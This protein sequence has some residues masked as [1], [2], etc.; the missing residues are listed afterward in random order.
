M[1]E[2][3]AKRFNLSLLISATVAVVVIL[4]PLSTLAAPPSKEGNPG[5]PGLLYELQ[6]QIQDQT[7]TIEELQATIDAL[8]GAIE[9]MVPAPVPKTGQIECRD[10]GY[11][12][13]DCSGTG[14]DGDNQAGAEWPDPRFTDNGDGT[15]TDKL[16]GLIW[17][18]NYY[19]AEGNNAISGTWEYAL[20]WVNQLGQGS[21]GLNDGS[22]PGD[23][24]LP[25][26]RELLSLIDYNYTAGIPI[27]L[28]LVELLGGYVGESYY[29]SSTT[30]P[31]TNNEETGPEQGVGRSL[32]Q[33]FY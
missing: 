32:R 4:L 9:A 3:C 6:N 29:W 14:Q 7:A 1:S 11:Q 13:I 8:E 30:A 22:A 16:T 31:Y 10:S 27:P 25:N 23:W 18:S 5:I 12:S 24:R 15:F 2:S 26:V 17:L 19:C 28:E 20:N 21:C 33:R